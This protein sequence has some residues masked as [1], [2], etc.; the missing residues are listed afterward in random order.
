MNRPAKYEDTAKRFSSLPS[1]TRVSSSENVGLKFK[2]YVA[3]L[4]V[5]ALSL[6][7]LPW[8]QTASGYGRVIAYS[9]NERQQ[10]VSAPVD[11]RIQH[12][13]VVEGTRVKKGDPIVDLSDNDPEMLQRLRE[14]RDALS[15]RTEA[16]QSAIRS[17]KN[18]LE[19]QKTLLEKGLSSQRT[20]EQANLEYTKYLMDEANASAELA[21]IDVRL[22]R[23]L[24]QSVQAPVD[25]T[26]LRVIPGQ[27]AQM[28]KQGQLLAVLVPDTSSRV[29]E[30][31]LDGNDIPLV[32]EG[33]HV[34]LQF[35]GWP[36]VQFSGWPSVAVG[37]FG[38][39]VSLLDAVDNG[40]GKFRILVTPEPSQPWPEP[41]Y[42]RQGVRAQGWVLLNRVALGFELWRRFNGFPPAISKAKEPKK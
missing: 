24:T 2:L 6:F 4:S 13:H 1:M 9:P 40:E 41:R 27:G 36:A 19:R 39:V 3:G 30:V 42:L 29:V 23:Q 38:G 25:G 34:R 17:A 33:D 12:W 11:G 16:A 14:E 37:T 28:V 18:N 20:F 32:S 21:R 5:L 10:E 31:W 8:Q 35:E 7:C 26:I 22:A 15:R